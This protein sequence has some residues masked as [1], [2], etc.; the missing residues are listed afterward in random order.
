MTYKTSELLAACT[1]NYYLSHNIY[2]FL[3]QR[4]Q[5]AQ[6]MKQQRYPSNG[7]GPI[8]KSQNRTPMHMRPNEEPLLTRSQPQIMAAQVGQPRYHA[9]PQGQIP[10]QA[11]PQVQPQPLVAQPGTQYLFPEHSL[12]MQPSFDGRYDI[13][14]TEGPRLMMIS[15]LGKN[16]VTQNLH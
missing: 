7:S 16:R 11:F 1:W 3:I 13:S 15:G 9:Y 14:N 4:T 6:R 10:V 2:S 12:P 5:E 8:V